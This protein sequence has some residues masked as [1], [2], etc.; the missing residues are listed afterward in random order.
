MAKKE[1]RPI[2]EVFDYK[3]P[4]Q[5]PYMVREITRRFRLNNPI[6]AQSLFVGGFTAL[7]VGGGMG[8]LFGFGKLTIFSTGL[9]TFGMVELFNRIE[10]DGKK[11]HWFIRD[12]VKYMYIYQ[13][14]KVVLHQGQCIKLTKKPMVYTRTRSCDLKVKQKI[15][16]QEEEEVR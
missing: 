16:K 10:P 2:Q 14:K 11:V 6:A 7:F 13:W 12:L 9:L 15:G 3:E 1:E 4:F 8:A 5:A